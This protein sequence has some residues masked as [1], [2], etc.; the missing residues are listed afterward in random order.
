[1]G[2]KARSYY[3]PPMYRLKSILKEQILHT[4]PVSV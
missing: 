1:M 2:G 3:T 4:L